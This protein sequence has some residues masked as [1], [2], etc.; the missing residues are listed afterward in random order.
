MLYIF[1]GNIGTGK[2]TL[3]KL[4]AKRKNYKLIYFDDVVWQSFK[5]Q[6]YD[7]HDNFLLSMEETQ[8][9]YD[10]MHNIAQCF[11][12]QGEN[13]ILESMYFKKQREQAIEVAEKMNIVYKI[14][15]ITCKEARIKKRLARRKKE[16]LQL[17]GLKLYKQYKN[18]LEPEIS[19]H[20]TIDTTNKTVEE[21]YTELI[22]QLMLA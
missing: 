22:R 7:K 14:I 17:P 12:Q 1:F 2:T 8:K 13:V 20:I 9:V 10:R 19:Y 3:A 11:L 4:L 5:K 21:S 15:E 18:Y 6:I 16:N